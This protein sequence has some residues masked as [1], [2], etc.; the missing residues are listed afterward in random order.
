MG[1]VIKMIENI[2][3]F[4]L[5]GKPI[6]PVKDMHVFLLE[7]LSVYRRVGQN[8]GY[9]TFYLTILSVGNIINSLLVRIYVLICI[10]HVLYIMM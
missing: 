7:F 5:R 3:F 1:H 6:R 2:A 9:T 10:M 4:L 8:N